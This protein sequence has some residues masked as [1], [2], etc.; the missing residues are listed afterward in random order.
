MSSQVSRKASLT[1]YAV[2]GSVVSQLLG[3]KVQRRQLARVDDRLARKRWDAGNESCHVAINTKITNIKQCTRLQSRRG[4][5]DGDFRVGET[6]S[7]PTGELYR[8]SAAVFFF[9]PLLLA[10]LLD[11]PDPPTIPDRRMRIVLVRG[12][13]RWRVVGRTRVLWGGEHRRPVIE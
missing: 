10:G 7:P 9:F 1:G 11:S 8:A 5:Q 4:G 13:S 2:V 3:K 6:C 12:A